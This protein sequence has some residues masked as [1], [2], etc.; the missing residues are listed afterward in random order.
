MGRADENLRHGHASIRARHHV[1]PPFLIAAHVDL[2]E[3]DALARQQP[4]GGLAIRAVAGGVNLDLNH[5]ESLSLT[6]SYMGGRLPATTRANTRTSTDAAPARNNAREQASMV[7]PEVSTSSTST[8]FRPATSALPWAGTRKAPW[9]LWARSDL[10]SPTCWGVALTRLSAPCATIRPLALAMISASSADWLNRRVH[11]R[12]QCSGT[13]TMAS[14]SASS[15]RPA[16]AIQR[17]TV[18]ARSSRSQYFKAWTS[19][20]AISS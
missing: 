6:I 7:A 19:L 2:G 14:L 8:S 11:C 3:L 12:R 13:G 5:D 9:T 1:A 15:S 4:L 10:S 16:R 17:P 20:R 18:G